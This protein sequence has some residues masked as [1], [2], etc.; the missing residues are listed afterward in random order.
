MA[1]LGGVRSSGGVTRAGCYCGADRA[2]AAWNAAVDACALVLSGGF[3]DGLDLA[4][5]RGGPVPEYAKAAFH[6]F[7]EGAADSI[8]KMKR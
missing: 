4:T 1:T 6:N 3:L 2:K 8:R 5:E 7:A